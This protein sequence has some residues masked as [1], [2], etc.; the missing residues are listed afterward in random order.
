VTLSIF[1]AAEQA[2]RADAL[3]C[4]GERLSFGELAERVR[5]RRGQLE[6][7][8]VRALDTRPVALIVDGSLVMFECLY[9]C[10]ALGVPLLPL[11]PRLTRPEREYL[12]DACGASIV[13]DPSQLEAVAETP[14]KHGDF[15]QVG[16]VESPRVPRAGTRRR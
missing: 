4:E 5:A 1:R 3:V 16:R 2:P 7:L 10:F 15:P 8:G 12:V 9:L 11:H 13:I 14:A 6:A